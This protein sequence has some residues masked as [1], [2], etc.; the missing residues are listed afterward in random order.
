MDE[1][2]YDWEFTSA[3][4]DLFTLF[5]MAPNE[6]NPE[7]PI[8]TNLWAKYQ[9]AHMAYIAELSTINMQAFE[10]FSKTHS[11][12]DPF[13][14]DQNQHF[15]N[16]QERLYDRLIYMQP[17]QKAFAKMINTFMEWVYHV[18]HAKR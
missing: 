4:S 5:G 17:Y 15:L 18:K 10:T 13:S 16:V 12:V 7:D 8:A 11:D 6:A 2:Q 9:T 14:H 3:S 1:L